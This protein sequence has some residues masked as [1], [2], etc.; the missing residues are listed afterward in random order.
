MDKGPITNLLCIHR[1]LSLY[2]LTANMK[3]YEPTE[4][5]AFSKV[6]MILDSENVNTLVPLVLSDNSEPTLW[7]QIAEHEEIDYLIRSSQRILKP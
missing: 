4:V 7:D 6:P 1:P 3:A 2:G 5:K